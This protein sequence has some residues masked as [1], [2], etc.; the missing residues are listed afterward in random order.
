[1]RKRRVPVF[2][3]LLLVFTLTG[4]PQLGLVAPEK[5]FWDMTPKEK[6]HMMLHEYNIMYDDYL[7]MAK[8][9]NLT[10]G[11]RGAMRVRKGVFIQVYPLIETYGGIVEGNGI[12][13][14]DVEMKI[15]QHLNFLGSQIGG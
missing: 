7:A 15:L 2:L 10:E 4:C 12:P 13:S 1:M 3:V 9:P 8:S 6:H 14:A 11:Q 5:S